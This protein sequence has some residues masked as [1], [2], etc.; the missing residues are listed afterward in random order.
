MIIS[1]LH[2]PA[3]LRQIHS[4][5]KGLYSVVLKTSRY[6]LKDFCNE[7]FTNNKIMINSGVVNT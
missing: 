6:S 5:E 4:Y 3:N 1:L 2:F 7:T